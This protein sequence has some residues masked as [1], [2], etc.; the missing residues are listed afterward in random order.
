[1]LTIGRALDEMQQRDGTEYSCR[2]LGF[3]TGD[4]YEIR[5]DFDHLVLFDG[6][7]TTGIRGMV[8]FQNDDP[9]ELL[10]AVRELEARCVEVH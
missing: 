7:P 4:T 6:R 10:N 8:R 2:P 3:I 1:M 9:A 5:I